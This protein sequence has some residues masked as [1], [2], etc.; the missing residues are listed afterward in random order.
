MAAVEHAQLH[1][2][3]RGHIPDERRAGLIP[4][5]AAAGK[6]ILDHPLG[7]RLGDH[8][9]KI[10][11]A[12]CIAQALPIVIRRCRND[13]VD[14]CVGTENFVAH[15][16]AEIGR[17]EFAVAGQQAVQRAAIGGKVVAAQHRKGPRANLAATGDSGGEKAEGGARRLGMGEVVPDIRIAFVQRPGGRIVMI[18]FLRHGQADDCDRWPAK[19]FDERRRVLRGDENVL[20]AADDTQRLRL[21]PQVERVEVVLRLQCVARI[22]TAQARTDDA[23]A[24]V[25]ACQHVIRIDRLMCAMK[26]ADAEMHD[27]GAEG[28]A[29]VSRPGHVRG[30]CGEA[31]C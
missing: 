23:P 30:Q 28:R 21:C 5:R 7:E 10:V 2:F 1:R 24:Q 17:Y 16:A 29:I 9:P 18:A 8:R 3:K 22:G 15:E 20:Q 26:R 25:A 13:T 27:A 12:H 4:G 14:H 6:A 11:E 31:C 19:R